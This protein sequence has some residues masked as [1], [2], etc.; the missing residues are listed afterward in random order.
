MAASLAIESNKNIQEI[1]IKTLQN[2]LKNNPLANGTL[3]EILIDNSDSLNFKTTGNWE[4]IAKGYGRY[5]KDYVQANLKDDKKNEAIFNTLFKYKT[6][7]KAYVYIP[8]TVGHVSK[9]TISIKIDGKIVLKQL[10]V[11]S[12]E[13][14]WFL[15]DTFSV[16]P[17][18]KA[19][20][21]ISSQERGILVAD[22][23]LW[24]PVS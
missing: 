6:N 7:Y 21:V 12:E 3:P 18:Q 1:E 20:L 23:V 4:K 11:E 16:L 22:A 9:L 10:N 14:D 24:V 13:S 15:I 17:N 8:K 2:R 19:E 5:G